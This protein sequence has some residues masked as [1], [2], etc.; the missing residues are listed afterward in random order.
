LL[1]FKMRIAV[2]VF[3][4]ASISFWCSGFKV[5]FRV[6]K[7]GLFFII[8]LS[9]WDRPKFVQAR[10]AT[11]FYCGVSSLACPDDKS[12]ILLSRFL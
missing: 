5:N 8:G 6:V 12:G 3:S 9:L 4:L 7:A 11:H 2:Q 10:C 1:L